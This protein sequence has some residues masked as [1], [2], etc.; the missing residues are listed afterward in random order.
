[1]SYKEWKE[2]F[3]SNEQFTEPEKHN[4]IKGI[5]PEIRDLMDNN[6]ITN[7]QLSQVDDSERFA[8]AIEAAK[9]SNPHGGSVDTHTI[10]ELKTFKTFL[11]SNDMAG[12]AVKPD[13]DIVAVF[14]NSNDK[15][16]GAVNDLIITAR[17]NGGTKMNCYGRE[18]VKK[19]EQCGYI[20]VARIPF[21]ADYVSDPELLERKPDVYAM[22][23]NSDTLEDVIKKCGQRA[24]KYS[25]REELDNLPTFEYDRALMYRD[26]L[27]K[28]QQIL[29]NE[30]D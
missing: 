19:Y 29:N 28:A 22:M 7:M 13:G 3:V 15:R 23:K 18:L 26:N 5:T 30:V 12:V 21:N 9:E 16:K 17:A 14:K 20:P 6:G 27:L 1:M 24:Y 10:E 8:K 4:I 25:T 11:S 2:K